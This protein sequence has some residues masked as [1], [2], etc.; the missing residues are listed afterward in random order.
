MMKKSTIDLRDIQFRLVSDDQLALRQLYDCFSPG[1]YQFSF[2]IIHSREMA[3]EIV[4]DV[5]VQIWN[6][7]SQIGKV[8]NLS[9]YLYITAR[10]ISISYLRKYR[11]KKHVS[12]ENVEVPFYRIDISP[13]DILISRETIG[14]INDSINKLPSQCRLV[15]KLVKEDGMKYREV[16]ELL[17]ISIKT[18]EN[19]VGIAL[20]K[21][22][23]AVAIYLPDKLPSSAK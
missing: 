16:A 5:F 18:V 23:A 12:F 15:F 22:H 10:N 13:E 4:E 20:K 17:N 14:R 19:Q 8:D 11:N 2:S 3:E 1:L 6:K 21:I 7:R 9:F